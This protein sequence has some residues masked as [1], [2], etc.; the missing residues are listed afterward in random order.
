MQKHHAFGESIRPGDLL[1]D[2]IRVDV[3]DTG[4]GMTPELLANLFAKFTQAP[5]ATPSVQIGD[6]ADVKGV[7]TNALYGTGL[8]VGLNNTGDTLKTVSTV[9]G[10]LSFDDKGDVSLPGYVFYEWSKGKYDY[11]K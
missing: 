2:F 10:K 6:L 4:P 11:M 1:G 3:R 7:R 5:G 8:V 9:I